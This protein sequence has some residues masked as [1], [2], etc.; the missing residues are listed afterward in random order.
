MRIRFLSFQQ[1]TERAKLETQRKFRKITQQ[2]YEQ[3]L[4]VLALSEDIYLK[5]REKS[6]EEAYR[7]KLEGLDKS[8]EEEKKALTKSAGKGAGGVDCYY[9]G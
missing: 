2:E 4:S 6:I 8:L 5:Q 1:D 9:G 7:I 3:G